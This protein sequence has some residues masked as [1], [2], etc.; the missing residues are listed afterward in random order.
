MTEN[1]DFFAKGKP[2][3][4]WIV[5]L[6]FVIGIWGLAFAAVLGLRGLDVSAERIADEVRGASLQELTE[7]ERERYLERLAGRI[8]RLDLD[9]RTRLRRTGVLEELFEEMTEPEKTVFLEATLPQ[10]MRQMMESLNA[11]PPEERQRLVDRALRNIRRASPDEIS[12]D[13]ED[14]HGRL[15]V[16]EGL[17]AYFDVASAETKL[18][19]A[20]LIEHLQQRLQRVN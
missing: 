17:K 10:G 3:R 7:A 5:A 12:R 1:I 18:E 14:V 6:G 2:G 9:E 13:L 15:I 20:P 4:R 16:E 11:M 8:N 19:V